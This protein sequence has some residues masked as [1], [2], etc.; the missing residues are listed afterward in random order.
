MSR[1]TIHSLIPVEIREREEPHHGPYSIERSDGKSE[2]LTQRFDGGPVML[3]RVLVAIAVMTAWGCGVVY[4]RHT[5]IEPA[6]VA[7]MRAW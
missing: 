6:P 5:P 4:G 7:E 2:R 3:A 1:L